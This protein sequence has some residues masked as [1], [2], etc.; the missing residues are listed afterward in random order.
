MEVFAGLTSRLSC[1]GL[2]PLVPRPKRYERDER[3]Q[4]GWVAHSGATQHQGHRG[5]AKVSF[6]ARAVI[7]AKN[8]GWQSNRQSMLGP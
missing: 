6:A 3:H 5:L 1:R 8:S 2:I 4:I 7:A